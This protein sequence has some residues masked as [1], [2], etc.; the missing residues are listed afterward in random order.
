MTEKKKQKNKH[1]KPKRESM[2]K[3][4]EAKSHA[5]NEKLTVLFPGRFQPFHNAHAHV[6]KKLLKRFN[7]IVAI[8]SSDVHDA[9][10]PF[11]SRQRRE[12]IQATFPD[13]KLEFASVPFAPDRTWVRALLKQVPRSSFDL[14]FSNNP[15]VRK[16]LQKNGI[17]CIGGPLLQR[18]RLEGRRIR[19]WPK[20]WRKA[21]PKPVAHYIE[22][23]TEP[24][25]Q[26]P[27]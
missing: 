16:Q 2:Q 5:Q 8:G 1:R 7:V 26:K 27:R 9:E 17:L 20:N 13:K 15:R 11:S 25:R 10:N 21:V 19:Q 24:Y 22:K 3:K 6:L 14:V 23:N 4:T 18:N 12:M